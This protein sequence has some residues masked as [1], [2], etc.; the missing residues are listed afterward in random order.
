VETVRKTSVRSWASGSWGEAW[1]LVEF[2]A[3]LSLALSAILG[4]ALLL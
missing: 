2:S 3:A 1:M 4:C